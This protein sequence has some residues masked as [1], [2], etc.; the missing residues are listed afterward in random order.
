MLAALADLTIQPV[1]AVDYLQSLPAEDQQRVL[2]AI[3]AVL[4]Y[5]EANC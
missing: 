1:G 5:A 4:D 2:M 3:V